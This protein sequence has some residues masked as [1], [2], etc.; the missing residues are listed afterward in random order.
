MEHS[1]T[2]TKSSLLPMQ[3]PKRN[4]SKGKRFDK[5]TPKVEGNEICVWNLLL[6]K[7]EKEIRHPWGSSTTNREKEWLYASKANKRPK[8]IVF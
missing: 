7:K 8:L 6:F 1:I 3:H 5:S 4:K 2:T